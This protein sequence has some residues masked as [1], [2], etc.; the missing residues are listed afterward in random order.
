MCWNHFLLTTVLSA[1]LVLQAVAPARADL[2]GHGG[3]IRAIDMS[4]DGRLVLTGSFDY[5]AIIWDFGDQQERARLNGHDGPVT[6]VSFLNSDR[7]ALTA[8]DDKTVILWDLTTYQPIYRLRG[9]EHK[10]MTVAASDDGTHAASGGW[11][12]KVIVWNLATGVREQTID[13][14]APVNS[15]VYLGKSNRLAVGGHDR[16]IR[17][18]DAASGGFLGK[19]EGH[20]MGITQLSASRDGSRLLS[21]SIDGSVRL[22]DMAA[23]K[24]IAKFEG[25]LNQVFSV[26]FVGDGQTAISSG[27]DGT[28]IH[29]D[30]KTGTKLKK[31]RAH[32][33]IIWA[34]VPSFDGRFT[35]SAGLDETARIW[36]LASGDRIGIEI[37]ANDEPKPWLNSNHPGAKLYK[38]CA[39]CHAYRADL[40]QRSGPHLEN[41]FGRR[42]G[43]VDGY[44][45]S[46]ALTKKDFLWTAASLFEL[47]DK[48]PDVIFP[49]TKMPIQKVTRQSQL[50]QLVDYLKEL[51]SPAYQAN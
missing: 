37:A 41:L 23:Y 8:S 24:E 3:M 36:H 34:V 17:V 51:T 33:S 6:S 45:Y 13:A 42:V 15:V 2:V 47:F 18:Y 20:L 43:S 16:I 31:I 29:W 21:A 35:V 10:V 11:D 22:W 7:Q 44:H 32:K 48:G 9:H 12:S 5:S 39:R 46:A 50:R 1:C 40:I 30:L 4:H 14:R 38:K 26:H 25:H 27:R 28:I 49:G 19:M